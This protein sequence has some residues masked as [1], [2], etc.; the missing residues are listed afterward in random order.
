MAMVKWQCRN[1]GKQ[2]STTGSV[3]T[4]QAGGK[5]PDSKSGNHVWEKIG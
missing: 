5:C 2:T 1:C 4:P 3:P